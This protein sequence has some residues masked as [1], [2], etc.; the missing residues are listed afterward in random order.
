MNISESIPDKH[1]ITIVVYQKVVCGLLNSAIAVDH[2]IWDLLE[3]LLFAA[4]LSS[5]RLSASDISSTQ[6]ILNCTCPCEPP[7]QHKNLTCWGHAQPQC[8]TGTCRTT[9]C[10]TLT[11]HTPSYWAWQTSY[12]QRPRLTRW[13]CWC[14]AAACQSLQHWSRSASFSISD[15]HSTSMQLLW[16][17]HVTIMLERLGMF[18][19]CWLSPSLKH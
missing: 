11:S 3:P 4:Y 5:F 1:T 7:T 6:T 13:C 16:S 12:V 15:W 8:V 18:V 17:S 9:C 2:D 10:W 19:I 14:S